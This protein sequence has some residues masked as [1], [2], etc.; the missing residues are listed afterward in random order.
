MDRPETDT[1]ELEEVMMPRRDE[2]IK[3]VETLWC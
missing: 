2:G 3:L 1:G